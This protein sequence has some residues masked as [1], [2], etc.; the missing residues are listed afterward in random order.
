M[1]VPDIA[2]LVRGLGIEALKREAEAL[3]LGLKGNR[4]RCPFPSCAHKGPGRERDAQLFPGAHPRVFCFA[5]STGGDLLDLVQLGRS[6]SRQDAIAALSGVPL[7]AR[8]PPQLH[9]VGRP[10]IDEP[11]KLSPAEV[12]RLWD[13]LATEDEQGQRYLEGRGLGDAAELGLVRF[14]TEDHQ[15]RALKAQARRGYRVAALLTDV[16]GNPRGIQMRV[17]R[18]PLAR[19][20]KILSVKGSA[21]T[22]AFFGSPDR[23]EAEPIIAV[24][25]GLA[26]TLSLSI[27]AMEKPGVAVVGAAGKSALP[28][29]A[30][31]LAESGIGIEGK[32]F[33]LF[34]QNDR[35]K[36]ASRKEFV[37][38]GQLLK[39]RGATVVFAATPEE[40]KDLAEWR[41]AHPEVE[42]PPPE[43]A[44]VVL[45]EPGDDMPREAPS[46][47]PPG[48]AVPIPGQIRTEHFAQNFRTLCALLDD[49][50]IRDPMLGPGEFT[51][52]EMTGS[53]RLGGRALSEVDL[54]AI[55]LH[56]EQLTQSTDGKPLKFGVEDI[57]QALQMLARRKTVHP[58]RDW[59]K[60]L[61]WDGVHRLELDLPVALGKEAGTLDATLL[62]RWMTSAVARAMAP[63]CQVDTV[64]VLYG[65]QGIGKSSFFRIL[66]GEWFTDSPV[67]VGE[68]DGKLI[69]RKAWIVEWSELE[70][71]RRARDQESI[72][73]FI[74][75]RE[76]HFRPPYARDVIAAPRS[77]V[78]V[79]TTNNQ[80]FLHDP[81]GSRRFFCLEVGQVDVR[82]IQENR[83][84]LWAEAVARYMRG[85]GCGWN[86]FHESAP[87]WM[88]WLSPAEAAQLAVQNREFESQDVWHDVI[89][90]WL[91]GHTYT[92]VTSAQLL[93]EVLDKELDTWSDWDAKRVAKVLLALGWRLSKRLEYGGRYRRGYARPPA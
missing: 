52:C 11:D 63:G 90:D 70:S 9:V 19:D 51:W 30:E 50:L 17:V 13:A 53:V 93:H 75:A 8:P 7:P 80:D 6:I 36:N 39:Q 78:I 81:T 89:A 32:Y 57:A 27:W 62:S 22:R 4:L 54:V 5:C 26:D 33:C 15:N 47:V 16:V 31:E 73:A 35:P 34:P 49:P 46:V 61:R 87:E 28:R 69:M 74:T 85:A 12:K 72:R 1:R 55:R 24:T 44:R 88:W 56:I 37:R 91:E 82:W 76:D 42:W 3:S 67:N 77:C 21:S 92:E 64:L 66:G 45:P 43:L 25:E 18:E 41:Q 65:G 68:K 2:E 48:C 86:R 20:P 60:T 10:P 59:L 83:E 58:V 38:L 14:A 84:Q 40:F 71:M 29:L 23:I 79:G